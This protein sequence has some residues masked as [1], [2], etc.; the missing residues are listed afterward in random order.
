M[1]QI[2]LPGNIHA[3]EVD[4]VP[5]SQMIRRDIQG[6]RALAVLMVIADHLLGYPVGGF[7]GVD[8]FFVISGFVITASLLRE[9]DKHGRVSF[10]GFYRRRV[11]RII[12]L[13]A[14]VLAATILASWAV[15]S[16]SRAKAISVDGIWSAAFAANWKFAA[17]GTDYF[18][19]SGPI[20]PLQHFWSLAVEEQFYIAWPWLIVCTLGYLATKFDWSRGQ[21]RRVLG[22]LFVTVVALSF[23]FALW[24][25]AVNPSV[26]YFSTFSRAWELSVGA[27]IAVCAG[28]LHSIPD[29]FR[30][31]M[32]YAGLLG[33]IWSA[34][35][36][37]ADRPF[38][39]P[40]AAI[41]VLA[42]GLVIA[43]GC[44]G[45]HRFLAPLTNGATRYLGDISYSLYLWHFP[46]V[47]LLAALMPNHGRMYN[48]V[49]IAAIFGLSAASYRFVENP[50]RVGRWSAEQLRRRAAVACVVLASL[51]LV[52]VATNVRNT[53]GNASA[54]TSPARLQDEIQESAVMASFPD[55]EPSID[56]PQAWVP[57]QMRTAT[58]CLNPKDSSDASLCNYGTGNKL[59]F[60]T[61]DSVAMSWVPAIAAALEPQG[62]RVHGVGFSD[63]PFAHV[64]IALK[65]NPDRA[66]VCNASRGAVEGQLRN[67]KP[68]LVI[69][70]DYEG[71]I[72]RLASGSTG[73]SAITEYTAGLVSAIEMAKR[74]A[75]AVV[76]IAPNP[77]GLAA[78]KCITKFSSPADCMGSASPAWAQKHRAG[79]DAA[80]RTGS[81]YV[82][83]RPWFCTPDGRCPLV[84]G[85]LLTRWDHVHLTKQY[86][87]LLG[88]VIA[89][90]LTGKG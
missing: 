62:Y 21:A 71:G 35:N 45:S 18:Q 68:D 46:V 75:P 19:A 12:P 57:E 54:A 84:V 55:T 30:P 17:A 23:A 14:V 63:C 51:T 24:D 59:A 69:S 5:H 26:A 41:P 87:S 79:K 43:A 81:R 22:L 37:T 49:A 1:S 86:A 4:A 78:D 8:V 73:E 70:V 89:P 2:T 40:W 77:A 58:Q 56:D 20:S 47:I 10:R 7:A 80:D 76:T 65:A 25:T 66:R 42:A 29:M 88:S 31:L 34:F 61:G 27:L 36:L 60:V 85:D 52:V 44:G 72:T 39:G 33:I 83:S 15:F 48:A 28:R 9:H 32:A 38:P 74:Y 64:Q 90:A 11:R 50:I 67:L 53:A 13:T 3:L 82:D 16:S 6:L